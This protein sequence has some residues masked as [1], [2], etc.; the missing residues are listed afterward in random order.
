MVSLS[1]KAMARAVLQQRQQYPS[2]VCVPQGSEVCICHCQQ[3]KL[4]ICPYNTGIGLVLSQGSF[5]YQEE[6]LTHLWAQINST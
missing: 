4:H 1:W 6:L 5:P 3:A 2:K